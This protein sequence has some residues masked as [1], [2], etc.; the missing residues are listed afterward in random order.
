[1][2]LALSCRT[3][4]IDNIIKAGEKMIRKSNNSS[5]FILSTGVLL[6]DTLREHVMALKSCTERTSLQEKG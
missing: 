3:G 5:R 6:Y 2:V 4:P 1:M